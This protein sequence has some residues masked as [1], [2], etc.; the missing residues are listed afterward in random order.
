[1][2]T[3]LNR[4]LQALE[5]AQKPPEYPDLMVQF[6]APGCGAVA[7]LLLPV[8]LHIDRADDETEAAFL[9]RVRGAA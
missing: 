3:A 9:A 6:V 7:A 4:R 5:G 1:M 2:S 8:G